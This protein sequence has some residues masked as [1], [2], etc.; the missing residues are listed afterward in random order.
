VKKF[1]IFIIL[2]GALIASFLLSLSGGG[3]SLSLKELWEALN[4]GG[5]EI[6]R[7][8]VWQ[9]R[10]PRIL[11][12]LLVGGGLAASGCVFQGMLRNPLADPYTLGISGGAAF[13]AA[14]G[15]I[16]SSRFLIPIGTYWLPLC[17]FLGALL[18]TV[19]VYALANRMY[20]STSSLILGGILLSFLFT[21]LVFLIFAVSKAEDVQRTVLWLMGDL[22]GAQYPIIRSVA[23][24]L[25][26][27]L[28]VLLL[29][30]PDLNILTLGEEKAL[31]LGLSVN[32]LVKFLFI[33]SALITGTCVSASG[34]IGFVGLMI[35][36]LTRQLTGPD[37]RI[38]VPA[39]VLTGASFLILA[40]TLARTV[41]APLELPVGVI[42][43]LLGSFFFLLFLFRK[44]SWEVF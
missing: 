9:I 44:S 30:T 35:P 17:A 18:A 22:S 36:H 10:L 25:A 31:H 6:N 20:F 38:L 11:L 41:V 4:Y 32:R 14:V 23:V 43:G 5:S 28:S 40:D 15:V 27:G 8:I 21:S 24:F 19:L 33:L 2:F 16:T 42:T 37:H 34:I 12:G 1:T 39:S 29:F 13:G 3:V 26:I 7:T